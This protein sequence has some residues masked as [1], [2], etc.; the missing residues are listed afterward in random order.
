LDPDSQSQ[1][2]SLIKEVSSFLINEV[3][4]SMLEDFAHLATLPVDGQ[5]LT[6]VLHMR[7]INIRYLG[8]IA[9]TTK[10]EF[11]KNLCIRE[12][13]TRSAKHIFNASLREIEPSKIAGFIA[14]FLNCFLAGRNSK[15][16]KDKKPD[17]QVVQFSLTRESLWASI[18]SEVKERFN[19]DLPD[20]PLTN[21]PPLPILRSFCQKV[22]VQVE[23]KDYVFDFEST[24]QPSD[25]L[26]V[27][28]LVKH[29]NP[30]V[31][32]DLI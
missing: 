13:I 20:T 2:E 11:I 25:I 23:A 5:T 31:S 27:F 14:N 30:R 15:D 21:Q 17:T 8:H 26:N 12:M 32:L 9:N 7:G 18:R 28:P 6:Q 3:I 24:F 29:T 10:I 1:D 22:G 16:S 4:P 19:Y